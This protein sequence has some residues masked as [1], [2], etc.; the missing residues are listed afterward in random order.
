MIIN[1]L[2]F[3]SLQTRKIVYALLSILLTVVAFSCSD[4]YLNR[5]LN[6]AEALMQE[7]P[8]SALTLL[9]ELKET[10]MDKPSKARF[11]LDYAMALD[12]NWVD[13]SDMEIIRPALEY[14]RMP[15]HRKERFLSRYYYARILEN[16]QSD[17][18]ALQ[19]VSEAEH[20]FCKSV[21]S[22]Y[23]I[24][25]AAMKARIY[26]R[27]LIYD[28]AEQAFLEAVRHSREL[29]DK[30]NE[31]RMKLSLANLYGAAGQLPKKDSVLSS[32]ENPL[33]GLE[34]VKAR[35][36][37]S[38][39]FRL[40]EDSARFADDW[41]LFCETADRHPGLLDKNYKISYLLF[42]KRYADVIAVLTQEHPDSLSR[43][44]QI[45]YWGN[46]M[47]AYAGLGAYEEAFRAHRQY[48]FL[49]EEKAIQ[50]FQSDIR[51]TEE[52]YESSLKLYRKSLLISALILC[53]LLLSALV[54]WLSYR[55]RK[56][57]AA[58]NSLR[59]EYEMLLRIRDSELARNEL[60]AKRL[61]IRL[62]A[63]KPYFTDK[64]PDEL[65]DSSELRRMTEDSKMMLANI[66]FLFGMYHPK[67]IVK[68]EEKGLSELEIGYCCLFAL[69]FT[70][71]EIP[72][73]LHRNSFYNASS[74]IRKKLGLGPH[75]TNL[76]IWIRNLY[77]E[78]EKKA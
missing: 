25:T 60:F 7:H 56:K 1:R 15:V 3:K 40:P 46:M 14:Y 67:F 61:D 18:E 20:L 8:D 48:S 11:S 9:R 19:A 35:A 49:V 17:E 75:D 41:R 69:G 10:H 38:L 59:E 76:S 50:E 42:R 12:K 13:T 34:L 31:L 53:V 23:L 5:V 51:A 22:V 71:N 16:G 33:P 64:F 66:G 39:V 55:R 2:D 30:E 37:A 43:S 70:G 52:C 4:A 65:Y 72:D 44:D 45:A 28:K 47:D 74:T 58:L 36:V 24:R 62:T 68:L 78:T 54:G 73:M 29:G 63:L 26:S 27:Q 6:R 57:E 21:D 32:M 77:K